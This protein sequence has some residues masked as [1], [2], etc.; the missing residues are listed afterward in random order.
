MKAAARRRAWAERAADLAQWTLSVLAVRND[1]WGYYGDNGQPYTSKPGKLTLDM[2]ESSFAATKPTE[3]RGLHVSVVRADESWSKVLTVDLDAHS[4]ADDPEANLRA[5]LAWYLVL[6]TLGFTP[7][8]TTS[9]GKGGFHLRVIFDRQISS[10]DVR[11]FGLWLTRDFAQYGLDMQPEVFPKQESIV[12][13]GKE[14]G[15]WVRLPGPHK[16][17]A[18]WSRAWDG[19]RWLGGA[20]AINLILSRQGDDSARIPAEATCASTDPEN[21]KPTSVSATGSTNRLVTWWQEKLAELAGD[22]ATASE[23]TRHNTLRARARILGGYLANETVRKHGLLEEKRVI[24]ALTRAGKVARLDDDDIRETIA[25]G[26]EN[27]KAEPLDWPEDLERPDDNGKA[28]EQESCNRTTDSNGQPPRDEKPKTREFRNFKLQRVEA[29]DGTTDWVRV[30]SSVH[31]IDINLRKII[32]EWPKRA[33][34][35]LF[36]QGEDFEPVYLASS[37]RLFAHIDA[38]SAVNWQDRGSAFVTQARYF[39]HKRMN[40]ERYDAIETLPHYPS[41]DNLYYMHPPL[42]APSGR[43]DPFLDYFSPATP[44]DRE[45]LKSFIL[46]CLSGLQPGTR[47]AYL[48]TGLDE[49]SRRGRGIG[50]SVAIQIIAET[51]FGG[52]VSI[53][54]TDDIANAVTRLLSLSARQR[55][56]VLIDNV[57]TLKLS[58]ADLEGLITQPWISG[59]QLYV[60][61]GRRPN[62]MI[63]VVTLNGAGL[64]KDMAQRVIHVKL[65]RPKYVAGW[66][67]DVRAFANRHRWEIIA[68]ALR[69]LMGAATDLEFKPK[70]RWASWERDVLSRVKL[71]TECQAII[72]ERR[73]VVDEDDEEAHVVREY[74]RNRLISSGH[75]PETEHIRIPAS[76]A[77]TWVEQATNSKRATNAASAYLGKLGIPEIHKVRNNDFRGWAWAAGNAIKNEPI[78]YIPAKDDWTKAKANG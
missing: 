49:D 70:T 40:A 47:P 42:P 30:P 34:E 56:I 57:K 4:E 62:T 7:L 71:A 10:R 61:E 38:R 32:G 22:V 66:N 51:L 50:K 20:E 65:N 12:G 43:L 18:H 21:G 59:R 72:D 52:Y 5:A 3:I 76:I 15:N 75:E 27:G 41:I 36:C 78:D 31:R 39:E 19:E 29:K 28:S 25:W 24:K 8:L 14:C 54:P 13:R 60:G 35:Q 44:H 6:V 58:W 46:T 45:L 33:D 53:L 55:R 11:R 67:E 2:L 23:G 68:D 73:D 26:L 74:F 1:R 16:S 64:S 69:L 48:I 17:M 9:D 77:A 37:T 63:I